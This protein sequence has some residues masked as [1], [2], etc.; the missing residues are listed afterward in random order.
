MKKKILILIFIITLV[1]LIGCKPEVKGPKVSAD[2]V[3]IIPSIDVSECL[4][5][6]KQ[7]NPEMSDQAANDNC[8]TIEAIN[9]GDKSLCD[10]VSESFRAN[11]LAQ[12]E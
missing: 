8:Y 4:A 3:D 7:T 12:F 5:Q 11:C 2:K 1:T 9:E 10:K 6:I